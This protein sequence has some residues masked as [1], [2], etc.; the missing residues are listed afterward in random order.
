LTMTGVE[1]QHTPENVGG[2]PDQPRLEAR[3]AFLDQ[4]TNSHSRREGHS[5]F[6]PVYKTAAIMANAFRR[7]K[8]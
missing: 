6:E 7:F 4:R 8:G 3:L 1:E 2:F 5:I